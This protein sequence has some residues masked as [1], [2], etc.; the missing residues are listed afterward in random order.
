MAS[1]FNLQ[2]THKNGPSHGF[3]LMEKKEPA[4]TDI[5][6]RGVISTWQI[7][8]WNNPEAAGAEL[9]VPSLRVQVSIHSKLQSFYTISF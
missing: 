7:A 9:S 2:L 5:P 1:F 6:S 4:C 3:A 8:Q